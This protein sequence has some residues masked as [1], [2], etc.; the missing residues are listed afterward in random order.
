MAERLGRCLVR[1][2]DCRVSLREVFVMID[3]QLWGRFVNHYWDSLEGEKEIVLLHVKA[4]LDYH[5]AN[6]APVQRQPMQAD[7]AQI[8]DAGWKSG[9]SSDDIA[10]EILREIDVVGQPK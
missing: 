10:A 8:V 6:S 1:G 4:V 3:A 5:A 7:V 9:K 2:S